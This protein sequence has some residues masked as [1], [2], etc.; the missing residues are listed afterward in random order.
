[1]SDKIYDVPGDFAKTTHINAQTY[2]EMYQRSIADPDGFW[3]E[4]ADKFLSWY[5]KWDKVSDWSYDQKDLHI[6]WFEGAQLNLSYNCIDRHLDQ[7]ADQRAE[8]VMGD[9]HRHT[10]IEHQDVEGLGR[11]GITRPCLAV[12]FVGVETA[13]FDYLGDVV[14]VGDDVIGRLI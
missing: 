9:A 12:H 7:R 8:F 6:K 1:M 2:E 13:A 5:K 14:R 10:V 3:A 4:Q 11:A